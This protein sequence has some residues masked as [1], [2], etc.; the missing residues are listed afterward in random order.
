MENHTPIKVR[1]F[2]GRWARG[3]ANVCPPEYAYDE[4]NCQ[5]EEGGVKS[6]VG[7]EIEIPAHPDGWDGTVNR[8]FVYK[9]IGQ[10]DII[11]ILDSTG[12]FYRSNA[13]TSPM[14]SFPDASDFSAVN[15]FNRCYIVFHNSD[16]SVSG[17][18]VYVYEGG[19]GLRIA[20]GTPPL[21]YTLGVAD[22]VNAGVVEAGVHLF[23]IAYETSSGHITNFGLAGTLGGEMVA[24]TAPGNKKVDI[25]N[26]PTAVPSEGVV[27]R[28]VVVTK[29]IRDFDG[30]P[31]DKDWFFLPG[32]RIGDNTT[33]SLSDVDF[34]DS[35]LIDSAERIMRQLD[36]IPGGSCI[37]TYEGRLVSVGEITNPATARVSDQ[38][39]PESFSALDG[40]I[41][42]DPGDA[43]GSLHHIIEHRGLLYFH[44]DHRTY[45]TK[46][47]DGAPSSWEVV[48]VDAALGTTVYGSAGVLDSKGH[49]L[50][51]F[52]VCCR[53]GLFKFQGTYGAE[54]ELSYVI[55]D[56][57]KRINPSKFQL[58][59]ISV[60]PVR[61]LLWIAVPLDD[62]T[63]N[64]A[65]LFCDYNEGL[66]WDKVKWSVWK[67][68]GTGTKN[69][70]SCWITIDS[71]TKET[72]FHFGANNGGIFK[73]N[74]TLNRDILETEPSEV[75]IKIPW[76]Y[77]MGG[78]PDDRTT[79]VNH[80]AGLL[81]NGDGSGVM[82]LSVQNQDG[83]R[84]IIPP[85]IVLSSG[86][87]Y[88][89]RFELLTDKARVKFKLPSSIFEGLISGWKC[90]E[91]LTNR[92]DY[93]GVNHL[94]PF[95]TPTMEVGKIGNA[96]GFTNLP[97]AQYLAIT[98]AAQVGLNPNFNSFSIS[99]WIYITGWDLIYNNF[100]VV[101]KGATANSPYAEGY[102]LTVVKDLT[103]P[104]KGILFA[105]AGD[106]ISVVRAG[107]FATDGV[108]SINK[109]YHVVMVVDRE[110]GKFRVYLDKRRV[111]ISGP[112]NS[113]SL[114][115][116]GTFSGSV[117][118]TADYAIG[119][120][121]Q[122][123][124]GNAGS[125]QGRVDLQY[126]W[127]RAITFGE[128]IALYNQGLGLELDLY[129][130]ARLNAVDIFATSMYEDDSEL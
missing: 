49:H 108:L 30:N 110:I 94:V 100:T 73:I 43:G 103:D 7:F 51:E 93:I 54:P 119:I 118:P 22:S 80:F 130:K 23:S 16:K 120:L 90:E 106:N 127:N 122:N 95:N 33:T 82:D 53:P 102:S 35:D 79:G 128:V 78:V 13:L 76:E 84:V 121:T 113:D 104:T 85:P 116:W 101:A 99:A 125:S 97:S 96:V 10:P 31:K 87:N 32:G 126:F 57:W 61:K 38:D 74:Y 105:V 45:V 44:K 41:N 26:I 29:V 11:L 72:I 70:A 112:G 107:Q 25:T 24:Y 129:S 5:F 77:E 20:G 65:F 86:R 64:N 67:V 8:A 92:F 39:D 114:T 1:K 66:H 68:L 28:H 88:S 117:N 47:T 55:E 83:S 52:L 59:Q 124:A 56:L 46:S 60:D 81:L 123:G 19:A 17:G 75:A 6:R 9:R 12:N 91:N 98:N 89:R 58:I 21:F 14:I 50:E 115:A 69:P 15:L 27:A 4:L 36:T 109:W 3:V 37:T 62:S 34:Y 63:V 111:G 2:L 42:V 71:D 18:V 48:P 40:F